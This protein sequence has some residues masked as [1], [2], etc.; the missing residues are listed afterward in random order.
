MSN[1]PTDD[2]PYHQQFYKGDKTDTCIYLKNGEKIVLKR[3]GKRCWLEIM[4]SDI[5][6][7]KVIR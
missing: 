6:Y 3:E 1:K 2:K 7:A 5:V 4:P